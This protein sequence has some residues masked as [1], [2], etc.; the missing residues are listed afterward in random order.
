MKTT[1]RRIL[2]KVA[3]EMKNNAI[4]EAQ[5]AM[6]RI[7]LICKEYRVKMCQN[8]Q[9]VET[10]RPYKKRSVN[11]NKNDSKIQENTAQSCGSKKYN[12]I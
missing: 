5:D 12:L 3:D 10:K 7:K 1:A 9:K 4:K 2:K 11:E 6:M 8:F